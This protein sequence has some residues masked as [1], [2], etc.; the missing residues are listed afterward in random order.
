MRDLY[1]MLAGVLVAVI[2]FL[3][4]FIVSV[5]VWGEIR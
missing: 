5:L 1:I 4:V 3:V 2:L